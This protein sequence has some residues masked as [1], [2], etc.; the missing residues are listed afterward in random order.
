MRNLKIGDTVQV[1]QWDGKT[2][3]AKVL[4]IEICWEG[5]KSGRPVKSC[6]LDAHK[7][8]TLDLDNDHWCYFYQ[9]QRVI[10]QNNGKE[11]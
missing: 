1:K 9:V 8:G 5:E 11:R 4:S 3:S 6:N 2:A 10:P 7:N